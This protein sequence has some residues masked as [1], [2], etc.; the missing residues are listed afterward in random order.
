MKRSRSLKVKGHAGG[1]EVCYRDL[2]CDRSPR[3]TELRCDH[4]DPIEALSIATST[5]QWLVEQIAKRGRGSQ[6]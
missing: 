1:P 3:L 6:N 2:A 5:P 4:S